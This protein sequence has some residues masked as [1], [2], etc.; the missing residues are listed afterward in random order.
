MPASALGPWMLRLIEGQGLKVQT[1]AASLLRSSR[2][3]A[4]L[5]SEGPL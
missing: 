4:S 1:I 2:L 3:R 5:S